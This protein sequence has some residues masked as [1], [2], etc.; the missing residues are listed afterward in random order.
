[1]ADGRIFALLSAP[2]SERRSILTASGYNPNDGLLLYVR[3]EPWPAVDFAAVH[4]HDG[5]LL[6]VAPVDHPVFVTAVLS[7]MLQSALG[8]NAIAPWH[9]PLD[10]KLLLLG[11]WASWLI[12]DRRQEGEAFLW[13]VSAR[14][15]RDIH[16]LA[17]VW[18]SPPIADCSEL[19]TAV[20]QVG[21]VVGLNHTSE[22]SIAE[23]TCILDMRPVLQ[24]LHS[25]RYDGGALD[26]DWL[27]V[28][29][30]MPGFALPRGFREIRDGDVLSVEFVPQDGGQATEESGGGNQAVADASGSSG[31]TFRVEVASAAPHTPGSGL[32][33]APNPL[34]RRHRRPQHAVMRTCLFVAVLISQVELSAAAGS[35]PVGP[36]FAGTDI[37]SSELAAPL[38]A[39]RPIATPC[40]NDQPGFVSVEVPLSTYTEPLR[41]LLED[42]RVAAQEDPLVEARVLL[43]TLWEDWEVRG[44]RNAPS[45]PT[46]AVPIRPEA[47]TLSLCHLVP[48]KPAQHSP[49]TE[50]YRLDGGQCVLP[51]DEDAV[52]HLFSR[53]SFGSLSPVPIGVPEASRFQSWVDSGVRGCSPGP[54]E[55]VVLTSDGSFKTRDGSAGWG[56]VVSFLSLGSSLPGRF[57]GCAFGPFTRDDV[58][59]A[60]GPDKADAYLA[61]V[62]G[63]LWAGLLAARLP[64]AR[65]VICRADNIAALRGV[66]G[67]MSMPEHPLCVFARCVHLALPIRTGQVVEYVHVEGHAGDAANELADGLANVGSSGSSMLP[68]ELALLPWLANDAAAARWL[69]HVCLSLQSSGSLPALRGPVMSWEEQQDRPVLPYSS[70][71]SPFTREL[72]Q[73]PPGGDGQVRSFSLVCAS[74]NALS[75]LCSDKSSEP[76]ASGLYGAAGRVALL[77]SSLAGHSVF[78]AGIQEART[79][80]GTCH[81]A[82]YVRYCS[83]CSERKAFGV[84]LWICKDP[85]CPPHRLIV[86]HIDHTRLLACLTFLHFKIHVLVGHAPHRAH[87]EEVRRAWW[88]ETTAL[89]RRFQHAGDWLL[90]FDAN[91]RIGSETSRNVGDWQADDEDK[92][93]ALFHALTGD[94]DVW[95]PSTFEHSMTGDGGT[96]LQR[97]SGVLQ[98]SDFVCI[99]LS[100]MN[101]EVEAWTEPGITAGHSAPDHFAAMCRCTLVHRSGGKRA[102]ARKIDPVALQD[103]ANRDSIQSII[104]GIPAI[105]WSTNVHD[106]AALLSEYLYQ[107][108]VAK[109]PLNGRRMRKSFLS[110]QTGEV[111]AIVANLRHAL[112]NRLV[113]QDL[114]RVRCAFQAW[115]HRDKDF[116]RIFSGH[117]TF[118]LQTSIAV[119]VTR[120]SEL[121]RD[122]RNLCR[123]DKRQHLRGLAANIGEASAQEVH[124]ALRRVLR[125]KKF[126]RNGP[127]PLPLLTRSDGSV[128]C[129]ETEARDEWRRHFVDLEG[130]ESV[131]AAKLAERCILRH[132][133]VEA[134]DFLSADTLPD[135]DAL[136]Q[137]FRAVH[138]GKAAGPDMIPPAVCRPFATSLARVFWPV[139]LKAIVFRTEPIGYKGG[140][141]FHIGKP[142]QKQHNCTAERGILVQAAFEKILHKLLRGAAMQGF[143]KRASPLQIGGKK[144]LSAN[145]GSFCSRAFLQYARTHGWSAGV[146]FSDLA[147]AYYSVVRE[148]LLGGSLCEASIEDITA[149]LGLQ[150]E[151]LQLLSSYVESEAILNENGDEDFLT[152]IAREIHSSTWFWLHNDDQLVHTKRGTRPGSSWADVLF[153]ILFSRVLKRRGDFS[154]EGLC[155]KIP[156]SGC[157]ELVLYDARRKDS[158]VAEMQDIV[159]ADD[160]ATCVL[161]KTPQE[162]PAAVQRVAGIQIDTLYAHGLRPNIGPKKTAAILAPVGQGSRQMRHSVFT[163]AKGK[164]PVLCEN[165]GGLQLD[166]VASYRHL[167]ATVTHNGSMMPEI[168]AKLNAARNAFKEGRKTVFCSPCIELERRIFLFRT[169]VL[170]VLLS[171]S[172]AWPYMNDSTWNCLEAG[173]T[174]MVRQVLRIP[175]D[176]HQNWSTEQ[177][178]GAAGIPDVVGLV[179]LERLRFLAQLF[180]HG[181]DAA[182]AVLQH[183]KPAIQAFD[184]ARSWLVKAVANT[185][186]LRLGED[187]DAWTALFRDKGRFKGLLKRASSWH[188]GRMRACARFQ[189]FCRQQW[190]AMPPVTVAV[191]TATHAC[192]LCGI[193]FFDF[194]SWSAHSARTHGYRARSRRYAVGTRCRACGAGFPTLASHRRHLQAHA[195]CCRAVEWDVAGLL[196]PV[197]TPEGH[198]QGVVTA[199][200][201]LDHLPPSPPDVSRDVVTA[202]RAGRFA[203]DSEIF[204]VVRGFVEPFHVLRASLRFWCEELPTGLLRSWAED[205]LLCMQVD[206]W[207]ESASRAPRSESEDAAVFPTAANPF[208]RCLGG[209]RWAL[210]LHRCATRWIPD[211]WKRDRP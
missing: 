12:D 44:L 155:P 210:V 89:C 83:G 205:V 206:L 61:E 80:A 70:L 160:L 134:F 201:G 177:I 91:C 208:P 77:D 185:S 11:A 92:A 73:R 74:C 123:R 175:H 41:T 4:L 116:A 119:L 40:R 48:P 174:G 170:S 189:L 150:P 50:V 138:P 129:T 192:L 93:G 132:S 22:S 31:C 95:A 7:D 136:I 6:V 56:V 45:P 121:G 53:I 161:T 165:R 42:A 54:D 128:C 120:I 17:V 47:Q 3:D 106:H 57:A 15:G 26:C 75:L 102:P 66:Q 84:E 113:A 85:S 99:P 100:W 131:D 180:C 105:S 86:L 23:V 94:L 148:L 169:Y 10:K 52:N 152:A 191:E 111:H 88:Q 21:V 14:T 82:R 158:T 207:C 16:D 187:W 135:L 125:P 107:N 98:R 108:L 133:D 130:G 1:M 166:A 118:R 36:V 19:G 147:A 24:G 5:D 139:A 39:H 157:R 35:G 199:G 144:G 55:S 64:Y 195:A 110:E 141:L 178:F 162:L 153:S 182:F 51:C 186:S 109:F 62:L 104:E 190:T 163:N 173:V 114:A 203:S 87:T 211:R 29:G 46:K 81:S 137:T 43:E 143:H 34:Q 194:H 127:S 149:S 126:R 209:P 103:P 49:A 159:Y 69:P 27:I 196:E 198:P 96:L 197:T 67:L 151:D 172:G 146:L 181:P 168:R 202:L 13:E 101:F 112:R 167:G 79:P 154:S 72:H 63:L 156:W 140:T 38:I 25:A 18:A 20:E 164:L 8:W 65:G 28:V 33:T 32:C 97:A 124:C 142:G 90:L 30:G 145:V 2:V 68:S 117:W 78:V 76:T 193:A 183:S 184:E 59:R 122:L 204:E 58:T 60:G 71:L 37:C 179:S 171:G 200:S 188:V 9:A 176:G 115:R